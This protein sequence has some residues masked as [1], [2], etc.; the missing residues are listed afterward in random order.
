MHRFFIPTQ[1][2]SATTISFPPE[3]ARQIA[4]VLRLRV[5][6]SVLV[7]DNVG[8]EAEVRL[9]VVDRRAVLGEIVARRAA[10]PEPALRLS[11]LLCLT[12]REKFELMLQ[13]C[14]ELGAAGF[15][16]VI[17]SRSLVQDGADAARKLLRWRQIVQ[18]AAE[19]CGRGAIPFIAP[20]Q[21]WAQALQSAAVANEGCLLAWEQE[22]TRT[23]KQALQSYSP[24][25]SLAV[26]VGPE[27]GLAQ[28][29]VD[30]AERAGFTPFSLGPRILRMETAAIAVTADVFFHFEN[31]T[32]E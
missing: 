27:G 26:L 21:G 31:Q 6:Q 12:Q 22:R 4:A 10:P 9:V 20:V 2:L 14:T 7:L 11:L 16:P 24:Q 3:T 25:A 18:E 17:S 23:L 19:Q 1:T 30:A 28:E 15:V 5:G 32:V 13:K 8:G 29:E